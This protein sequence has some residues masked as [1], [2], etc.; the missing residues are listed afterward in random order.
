MYINFFA[1]VA[2]YTIAIAKEIIVN[3]EM[4]KLSKQIIVVEKTTKFNGCY[5]N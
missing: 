5:Q 3:E 4:T 2:E 1:C